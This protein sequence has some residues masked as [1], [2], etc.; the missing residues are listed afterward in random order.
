MLTAVCYRNA[1]ASLNES[2]SE[3]RRSASG[4]APLLQVAEADR[5]RLERTA[6][7]GVL[8]D[9]VPRRRR[10]LGGGEDRRPIDR[11]LAH[12]GEHPAAVD[13]PGLRRLDRSR[14]EPG[15]PVLQVDEPAPTG[16]PPQHRDRVGP[17]VG[18]PVDVGLEADVLAADAL[19]DQVEPVAIA[20]RLEL[21]VVVV[22]R[23]PNP[24][25]AAAPRQLAQQLTAAA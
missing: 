4:L 17:G 23:E 1:N 15:R 7:R 8:L 20:D 18:D 19:E 5:R 6:R 14:V 2:Q 3:T 22:V 11:S 16:V 10:G 21:A 13:P 12:L 9:N 25:R 24:G